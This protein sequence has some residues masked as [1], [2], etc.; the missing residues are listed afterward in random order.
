M[1]TVYNDGLSFLTVAIAC[2]VAT[3]LVLDGFT[4]R[5]VAALSVAL[6]VAVLT[7][8]S[9]LFVVA[10]GLAAFVCSGWLGEDRQTKSRWW[11]TLGAALLVL[12]AVIAT[13]CW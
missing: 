3:R 11:R 8:F 7:R 6:S 12:A 5:R 13:S 1:G 2:N 10:C 9:G 4:W